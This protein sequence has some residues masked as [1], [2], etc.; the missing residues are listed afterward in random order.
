MDGVP[1][2][3]WTKLTIWLFVSTEST[4][5]TDRQTDG[6][7]MTTYSAFMHSIARQKWEWLRTE[8]FCMQYAAGSMR[9]ICRVVRVIVNDLRW[10]L[11]HILS[12]LFDVAL[13]ISE[14]IQERHVV[15]ADRWSTE[16]CHRQW[17]WS[18]LKVTSAIFSVNK[19][20][21]LFQSL[22]ESPWACQTVHRSTFLSHCSG[23]VSCWT[24]SGWSPGS[25]LMDRILMPIHTSC[26]SR[27]VV[28]TLTLF[29]CTRAI[30][31]LKGIYNCV[32]EGS[33]LYKYI[34]VGQ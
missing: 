24:R 12:L 28:F 11:S 34:L 32:V 21:L 3:L 17:R 9:M 4:N 18:T 20:F 26:R 22:I 10:P 27:D 25:F 5:V 23:P 29:G 19:C 6:H 13:N 30:C 15:T 7:R 31:E 8:R 2:R 1:S 14:M 16:L 33:D